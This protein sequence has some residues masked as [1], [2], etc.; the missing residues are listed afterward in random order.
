MTGRPAGVG[1]E[2]CMGSGCPRKSRRS[3]KN[4]GRIS[5]RIKASHP[6]ALR[7]SVV[8]WEA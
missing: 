2:V 8:L 6:F 4:P 7:S 3:R 1:P 5:L